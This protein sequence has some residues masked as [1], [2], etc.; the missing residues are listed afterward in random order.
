MLRAKLL[1][2]L[3]TLAL[4]A[5]RAE[6]IDAGKLQSLLKEVSEITG[7]PIKRKVPAR[8]ISRDEWK[9]WVDDEV[10]RSVKPEEIRADELALRLFGL[11]PRDFDLRKATV[12]LLGEQAAAVYDPKRRQML[13]VEGASGD[14]P[15]ADMILVHELAHALADQHFNL[16][17]FLDSGS[18]TGEDATARLAVAEG[19]AMWVMLEWQV[20]QTGSS[21]KTNRA[22]L[23]TMLPMMGKLAAEQYPVFSTAPLYLKETLLFPYSAGILFQQAAVEKSPS[24]AFIRVLRDPPAST[25][26]I[27]HPETWF[28]RETAEAPPIPPQPKDHKTLV[29]GVLGELDLRIL[30]E[31][32][33]SQDDAK[34]LSPDWRAGAYAV[35]ENNREKRP[36][37]RWSLRLASEQSAVKV[38]EFWARMIEKKA[39]SVSFTHRSETLLEGANRD[40][41]F[42]IERTGAVLTAVEGR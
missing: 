35:S 13:V 11:I 5:T 3:L 17:A 16:K 30:L 2:L 28:N 22:A 10:R 25:R 14:G 37:L 24:D 21:L 29:E 39:E 36:L 41:A 1:P 19:Q 7:L 42:R 15:M 38:L 6:S 9:K 12:D 40:G 34:T 8:T 4:D 32:F 26:H 20:R 27:L 33:I 23:D 18:K 31:Q